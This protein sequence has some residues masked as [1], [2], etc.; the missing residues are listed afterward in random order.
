MNFSDVM[1]FV[2]FGPKLALNQTRNQDDQETGIDPVYFLKFP[3]LN[4]KIED[5][6][7]T[8]HLM[9]SHQTSQEGGECGGNIGNVFLEEKEDQ[10]DDNNSVQLR[11]I[12][13]EEEDR[14]NKNVTTKEVKSKRKR[15]RTKKIDEEK[16]DQDDDN[17]KN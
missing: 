14:E 10:D 13:G 15:A 3:V 16:E 9:P 17:K 5:H 1:Q 11:F 7:Q 8:Q 4:D 6:N 2:D 12:G